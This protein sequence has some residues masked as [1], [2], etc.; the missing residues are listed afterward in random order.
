MTLSFKRAIE[1]GGLLDHS[2]SATTE[3]GDIVAHSFLCTPNRTVSVGGFNRDGI[4]DIGVRSTTETWITPILVKRVDHGSD[5]YLARA[6]LNAHDLALRIL[7]SN[8]DEVSEDFPGSMDLTLDDPA[9]EVIAQ[10]GGNGPE[11]ESGPTTFSLDTKAINNSMLE[12][13]IW[14]EMVKKIRA[15]HEV[16]TITLK[17]WPESLV[18]DTMTEVGEDLPVVDFDYDLNEIPGTPFK[19]ALMVEYCDARNS[20]KGKGLKL[21]DVCGLAKRATCLGEDTECSYDDYVFAR[22]TGRC[23]GCATQSSIR[24]KFK[25]N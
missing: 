23:R 15:D 3:H 4:A 9:F 12:G 10:L 25:V 24:N 16:R 6:T 11:I 14:S 22:A 8:R 5:F 20:R 2:L 21:K 13:F 19:E 18:A 7:V 1:H 17:V